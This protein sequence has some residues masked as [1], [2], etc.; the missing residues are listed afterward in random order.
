MMQVIADVNKD[1]AF[2]LHS[3]CFADKGHS[4]KILE[5][6]KCYYSY[7][8]KRLNDLRILDIMKKLE[9]SKAKVVFERS[10]EADGSIYA[11][12]YD[13]QGKINKF[14]IDL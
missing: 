6:P 11:I 12:F 7:F 5:L 10:A 3:R 14:L 9:S 1:G 8:A 13:E 4:L 2:V